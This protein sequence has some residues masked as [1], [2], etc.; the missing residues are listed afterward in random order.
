MWR[1]P[2]FSLLCYSAARPG[3]KR[4]GRMYFLA[5]LANQIIV[6]R[7]R[8][9]RS[10]SGALELRKQFSNSIHQPGRRNTQRTRDFYQRR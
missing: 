4:I 5:G 8:I 9:V 1:R 2:P 6:H 7:G 10:L 3:S